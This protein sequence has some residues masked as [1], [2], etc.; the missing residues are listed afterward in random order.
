M[1]D[2]NNIEI[3]TGDIVK[4]TGGFFKN[5]NGIFYVRH[6][7]G[8]VDWRGNYHS[9]KRLNKNGTISQSKYATKSY[10]IFVTVGDRIK[11]A[12]ANEWNEKNAQIEI[13]ND[14]SSHRKIIEHFQELI[15]NEKKSIE[16]LTW[17][18]GKDNKEIE[19][20]KKIIT[21]YENVIARCKKLDVIKLD[22][23][24]D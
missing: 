1:L 8:D 23:L 14:V 5:D 17:N 24:Y 19:L 15:E 7:E 3:K 18:F 13:I 4:I 11:R 9:L 6:S 12:Q 21:H 20:H 2:K 10:P 22:G 16:W